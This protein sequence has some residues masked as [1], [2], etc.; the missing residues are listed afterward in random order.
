MKGDDEMDA[1][2]QVESQLI[3]EKSSDGV[4]KKR[5]TARKLKVRDPAKRAL[6]RKKKES[7]SEKFI[8]YAALFLLVAQMVGLVLLMRY[9]R[10]SH[11]EGEPMYLAST[12][13]FIMECMKLVICAIVIAYQSGGNLI[14][15]LN[16]H[17]INLDRI[18]SNKIGCLAMANNVQQV[19]PC[20]L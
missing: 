2:G 14:G 7:S 6:R 20:H 4:A 19:V 5:S 9:S 12:A 1:S 10:T 13:V 15:E 11:T 18:S 16:E 3:P 17:V 8:K